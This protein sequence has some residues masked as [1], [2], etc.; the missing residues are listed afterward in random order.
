MSDPSRPCVVGVDAGGTSTRALAVD[1]EGIVLGSGRAG[2]ANPNAHPP[3]QAAANIAAAIGDALRDADPAAVRACVVGMA[4]V[5]KLTDPAMAKVFDEA[6][7]GLGLGTAVRMVA[8]AEAAFASATDAPDGTVLVAGTGSIAARIRK[9]RLVSTAGGYGWLLGDEGSAFWIGREA[10]RST[11]AALA[12]GGPF[13]GLPAAVLR[14]ALHMSDLDALRA[15]TETDRLLTSRRLITTC[16]FESPIRLAR[17]AP[18]VSASA[19]EGDATA[20]EITDRAA[21]LLVANA[22]AAREDGEDTPVVIVGSV[23]VGDSPVGARVRETLSALDIRSATDG[24]LGA[25]WLAAVDAFGENA[26]RP[27][28][29]IR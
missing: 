8:D 2:G 22:L 28:L 18:L 3:A 20:R 11:L 29:E 15:Q 26:P 4:G 13:E 23:L 24:V 27:V 14:E 1:A 21:E 19:A 16:N 17:F 5:S 7:A 10:V 12:T 9:R 6:W 25:A